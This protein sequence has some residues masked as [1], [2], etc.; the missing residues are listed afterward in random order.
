MQYDLIAIGDVTTDC[1][2]KLKTAEEL[3]NHGVLEL[4]MP[5]GTKLEYESATE[6]QATGN[7]ANA[8]LCVAKLGI[9]AALV[10]SVGDDENGKKVMESLQTRGV[11]TEYVTVHPNMK[12]N[13]YYILQ[14]GAERTILLKHEPYPK[15]IPA[16]TEQPQWLYFSSAGDETFQNS[17]GRYC[18]E[19]GSSLRSNRTR[20]R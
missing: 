10:S 11:G 17:V 18:T 1:F 20:I 7:S 15:V 19:H 12:T 16:I 3:T 6:V 2:I 14:H 8:A 4:C 13:Y 9:S 5:F